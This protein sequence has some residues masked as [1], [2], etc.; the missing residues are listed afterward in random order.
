MNLTAP[1][2]RQRLIALHSDLGQSNGADCLDPLLA[3]L[4]E[5]GLSWSDWPELFALYGMSSSQPKRLRRWVRGVHE[6]IGR[7]STPGERR[8][9]R[10]G[11][12]R[13]LGEENLSWTNDLPGILASE[14]RDSNPANPNPESAPAA[15]DDVNVFDVMTTVIQSRVVLSETQYTV[16]ALWALN[17]YVYDNYSHAPQLGIVAPASSCGKSTF[18]KVLEATAH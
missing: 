15:N 3:V 17:T 12:I 4:A 14:W 2:I 6:L 9:A 13:R 5:N 10:D 8:K 7:A 18:R 16:A 11:L 1:E